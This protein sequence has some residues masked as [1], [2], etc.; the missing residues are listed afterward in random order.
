MRRSPRSTR[1][2][3][4][5]RIVAHGFEAVDDADD[6]S[7]FDL[8]ILLTDHDVLDLEALAKSV[9]VILDTRGAYRRQGTVAD[10]VVAL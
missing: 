7:R 5:E 6:L 1:W 3:A 8:A 9:P 2:S 10:G 4:A